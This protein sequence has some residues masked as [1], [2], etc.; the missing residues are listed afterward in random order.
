MLICNC[1]HVVDFRWALALQLDVTERRTHHSSHV[2]PL[3]CLIAWGLALQF[4]DDG[5]VYIL[6]QFHGPTCAFKDVALQ[7]VGNLF[8]FFLQRRNAAAPAG[9]RHRITVLG[10]T[11][12]DT[13]RCELVDRGL[14]GGVGAH[15]HHHMWG[16]RR[17]TQ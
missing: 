14:G 4:S 17:V 12:G 3:A 10:A 11:S 9:A 16:K 8:E 2:P 5:S 1:A 7:F 15:R 6:E 13:G